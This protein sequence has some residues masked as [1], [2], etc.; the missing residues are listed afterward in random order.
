M[1]HEHGGPEEEL[2]APDRGPQH[3]DT[4]ADDREPAETRGR[5]GGGQLGEHPR[6]QPRAGL[7]RAGDLPSDRRS[8]H[9]IHSRGLAAWSE[10]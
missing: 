4:G 5:R 3:D 2:A 8:G 10:Q 1:P 6:I 9:G 7:R